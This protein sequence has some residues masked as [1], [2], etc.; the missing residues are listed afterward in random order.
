MSSLHFNKLAKMQIME[1][2]TVGV[3]G[4]QRKGKMK[5]GRK[6]DGTPLLN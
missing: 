5:E 1:K 4:Q 3:K 2:T 6:K